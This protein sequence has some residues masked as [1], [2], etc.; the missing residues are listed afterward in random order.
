MKGFTLFYLQKDYFIETPR[1]NKTEQLAKEICHKL[2]IPDGR[3]KKLMWR[4]RKAE[5]EIKPLA[6]G[7][8][9]VRIYGDDFTI[10]DIMPSEKIV[11]IKL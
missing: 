10:C 1:K 7:K 3:A 4:L 5:C 2:F 8:Q 6:N 11:I 9:L